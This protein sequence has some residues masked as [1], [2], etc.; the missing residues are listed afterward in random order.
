M[1][2]RN[3]NLIFLSPFGNINIVPLLLIYQNVKKC[4][5]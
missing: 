5:D 3:K 2:Y 1:K 4:E